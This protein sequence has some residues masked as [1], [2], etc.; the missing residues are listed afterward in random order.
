M[1]GKII[2]I[3]TYIITKYLVQDNNEIVAKLIEL[4]TNNY[5]GPL[6]LM[7]INCR[8]CLANFIIDHTFCDPYLRLDLSH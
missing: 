7:K 6:C 3:I 2:L 8:L 1:S 5:L 4:R